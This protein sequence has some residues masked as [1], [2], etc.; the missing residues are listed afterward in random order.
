MVTA[1]AICLEQIVQMWDDML[2]THFNSIGTKCETKRR[3]RKLCGG[4]HY[5]QTHSGEFYLHDH[6]KAK[7]E[8][9]SWSGESIHVNTMKATFG[10]SEAYTKVYKTHCPCK[11]GK[12]ST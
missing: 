1:K 4:Y 11:M 3:R 10:C 2:Q 12:Q 6:H 9:C 7:F 5:V 8:L